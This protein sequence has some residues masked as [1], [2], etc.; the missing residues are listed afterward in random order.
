M[1]TTTM[2]QKFIAS[3]ERIA[4]E[5]GLDLV[6]TSEWPNRGWLM[7][8]TADFENRVRVYYDFQPTR[9]SVVT[10]PIPTAE[11]GAVRAASWPDGMP[12]RLSAKNW[13]GFALDFAQ[14]ETIRK[15]LAF[16]AE[17]AGPT[18]AT[19]SRGAYWAGDAAEA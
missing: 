10:G 9:A 6:Q 3:V 15:A 14:P 19:S 4:Q 13:L 11:D 17:K 18:V 8:Q 7:L 2:Q 1:P 5:R 16:I 12:T